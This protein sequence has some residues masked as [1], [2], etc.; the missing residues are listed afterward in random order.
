MAMGNHTEAAS[1]LSAA[2]LQVRTARARGPWLAGREQ[3][4]GA[5][6]AQSRSP[7]TTARVCACACVCAM[8][9]HVCATSCGAG[10]EHERLRAQAPV[11]TYGTCSMVA[12]HCLLYTKLNARAR[13]PA[14]LQMLEQPQLLAVMSGGSRPH[15]PPLGA[16]SHAHVPPCQIAAAAACAAAG[17]GGGENAHDVVAGPPASPCCPGMQAGSASVASMLVNLAYTLCTEGRHEQVGA[18]ACA[19]V[20]RVAGAR[21]AVV[22]LMQWV[23]PY[24]LWPRGVSRAQVLLLL[25]LLLHP[26]RPAAAAAPYGHSSTAG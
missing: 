15:V 2:V 18:R 8:H 16:P 11:S 9:V 19:C 12:S 23:A 21:A 1:Y 24:S 7:L 5:A 10:A 14:L 20:G 13:I 26:F 6:G 17:G 22:A 25:L 3:G 4:L